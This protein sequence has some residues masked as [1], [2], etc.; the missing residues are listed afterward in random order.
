MCTAVDV[1]GCE[2]SSVVVRR[3]SDL[4][5]PRTL[6]EVGELSSRTASPTECAHSPF[7]APGT[8]SL[9][10]YTELAEGIWYPIG[11]FNAV[12]QLHAFSVSESDRAQGCPSYSQSV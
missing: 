10:Q 7:D 4:N 9:L 1:Y 11:G 12:R 3:L 6:D 2:F 8:Y 5:I